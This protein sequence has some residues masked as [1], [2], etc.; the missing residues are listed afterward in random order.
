MIESNFCLDVEVGVPQVGSPI[1]IYTCQG[2]TAG[3]TR[4]PAQRWTFNQ[5]L[6]NQS[7]ANAPATTTIAY[8]PP[9][10]ALPPTQ[11]VTTTIYVGPPARGTTTT[12]PAVTKTTVPKRTVVATPTTVAAY[13]KC[14]GLDV[15]T[16]I[17][18]LSAGNC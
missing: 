14:K 9:G 1:Q 12:V 17:D 15:Y 7:Q 4:I 10:R 5:A 13:S 16:C 11:Q 3:V 8:Q 6:F 2:L 18:R